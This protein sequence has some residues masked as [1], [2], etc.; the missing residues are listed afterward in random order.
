MRWSVWQA[1][2]WVF[3]TCCMVC[4]KTI[5]SEISLCSHC[6]QQLPWLRNH[7]HG[8]GLEFDAV[9]LPAH[10]CG[11]CAGK[12]RDVDACH[13]L[14]HYSAPLNRLIPAFKFQA[15]FD[16]GYSLAR[17]LGAAMS[18]H[19]QQHNAPDLLLP[20]PQHYRRHLHR[21]FNQS[22]ELVQEVGR[23]TAIPYSN[24]L[25]KKHKHTRAQSELG[26]ARERARNLAGAFKLAP[27]FELGNVNRVTIIDDVV[28]TMATVSALAKLL[29]SHG[30][31]G[32][33]V[34]CVA[35][36]GTGNQSRPGNA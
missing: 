36:A 14:F 8:C 32:I 3:P 24:K 13:G 31:Q 16:I 20:V 21:G 12:D 26:S 6:E 1:L 9:E 4:H 29:K 17:L 28:T 15:R 30:I 7:C 35:R 33:E 25:L 27:E 19:Y 23:V 2:H 22:W 11:Q 5:S 34:W 18:K 10:L